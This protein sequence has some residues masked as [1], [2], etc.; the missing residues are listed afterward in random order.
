MEHKQQTKNNNRKN[1]TKTPKFLGLFCLNKKE[2][3]T[4]VIQ[5]AQ[6]NLN[7]LEQILQQQNCGLILDKQKM[8]I[9]DKNIQNNIQQLQNGF[10]FPATL[11]ITSLYCR[12]YKPQKKPEFINFKEGQLMDI[13]IVGLIYIPN[14]I[15][16]GIASV[17]Q[18]QLMVENLCPHLTMFVKDCSPVYSNYVIHALFDKEQNGPLH[19]DFENG[20]I[21]DKNFKKVQ[22]F[23]NLEVNC[24]KQQV[25]FIKNELNLCIPGITKTVY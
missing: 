18:K 23:D 7:Y 1:P 15:I 25:I 12:N 21:F 6:E 4:Q 10:N 11:H 20:N 8:Q 2:G 5:Y 22:I 16:F 3:Q 19:Q 13:N 24:K 17:D 9:L 14:K